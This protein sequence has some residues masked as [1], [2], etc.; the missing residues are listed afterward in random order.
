MEGYI[1]FKSVLV[2]KFKLN[3]LVSL[4]NSWIN[5]NITLLFLIYQEDIPL[6]SFATVLIFDN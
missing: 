4:N 3:L 1:I 2:T 5:I 6:Y